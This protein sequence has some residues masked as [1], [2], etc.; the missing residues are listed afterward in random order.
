MT[1][2]QISFQHQFQRNFCSSSAYR[3]RHRGFTL[4]EIL[5]VVVILGILAAIVVPKM[6][7][8]SQTARENTLR[9]DL[10]FLRTQITVYSSQHGEITP[11]YPGGNTGQSPTSS[12]F[13]AQMTNF[14]DI[15]G[16][17]STTG[18]ATYAFGPYLSRM[19]ENPLNGLSTITIVTGSGAMTADGTTGW[20]YQPQTGHIL[21][22]LSGADS[23][24]TNFSAY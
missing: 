10:R 22:N 1:N 19:P 16:N 9:D 20:L 6:S 23:S 4:V 5:I 13:V 8:A 3:L 12:D 15:V 21:P 17:T 18:S 11:G 2:N 24:G 7:N 14:T